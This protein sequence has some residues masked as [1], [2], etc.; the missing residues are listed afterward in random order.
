VLKSFL[1]EPLEQ[2]LA[3]S[4]NGGSQEIT[5]LVGSGRTLLDQQIIIAHP[6]TCT[7]CQP[8]EVGE[9][10]VSGY[11]VA[12]GYWERFQTTQDTFHAYLSDT[13]EGPFLRTG[14][15]GFLQ[16]GGELFVTGAAF[17]I[18]VDSAERLVIVQEVERQHLRKLDVDEVVRVIRQAVWAQ[19]ELSV[20]AVIL[21]KT[22][23]VPKTSSGKIQRH[24]CKIGFLGDGL[25]VVGSWKSAVIQTNES[26]ERDAEENLTQPASP[27][28][29]IPTF[30]P[31][32]SSRNETVEFIQ[33]WIKNWLSQKLKIATRTIDSGQSFAEY[34]LDSVM[35]V[36]LA[37]NLKSLLDPNQAFVE[38]TLV[39]NFSTIEALSC[40]LANELSTISSTPDC[41]SLVQV[42]PEK[43]PEH[44]QQLSE[45]EMSALIDTE[46]AELESLLSEG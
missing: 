21:L 7:R 20:F 17:S 18:E 27:N 22:G 3:V 16:E 23:H 31:L 39:W 6:E 10:W 34:G 46:L 13:G 5:T 32:N 33:N 45:Q 41:K 37:E 38:P 15:L 40:Y 30:T 19:H 36:E 4:G 42:D 14:D 26:E 2:H 12:K 8:N 35:A 44:L 25:N 29:L 24:A 28:Q 1:S 9:I 11:N 43:I